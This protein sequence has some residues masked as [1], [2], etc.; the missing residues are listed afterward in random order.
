MWVKEGFVHE[1]PKME[2]LLTLGCKTQILTA[3]F[4]K[5]KGLITRKIK[6]DQFDVE[7]K[8]I[9]DTYFCSEASSL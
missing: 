4:N 2:S 7:I 6:S 8:F 1:P 9:I 5:D 3:N